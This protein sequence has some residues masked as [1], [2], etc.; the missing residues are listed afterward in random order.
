MIW[1]WGWVWGWADVLRTL[2]AGEES[3]LLHRVVSALFDPDRLTAVAE[4]AAGGAH[5]ERPRMQMGGSREK[6]VAAVTAAFERHGAVA[7]D[8]RSVEVWEDEVTCHR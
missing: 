2:Q 6:A 1:G 5:L 4:R 7:T 3:S 8:S